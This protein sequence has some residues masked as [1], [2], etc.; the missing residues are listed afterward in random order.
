MDKVNIF[1]AILYL[2]PGFLHIEIYRKFYP[3]KKDT[4]FARTLHSVFWSLLL[5]AIA[6]IIDY[7][8]STKI[9]TCSEVGLYAGKV[10]NIFNNSAVDISKVFWLYFL[11][12]LSAYIRVFSRN[13]RFRAKNTKFNYFAPKEQNLWH[14]INRQKNQWAVIITKDGSRY[15]GY[16]SDYTYDIESP[17]DI[18]LLLAEASC[19][20][21]FL[22]EKYKI[23]GRG[24]YMKIN[25][26]SKIEFYK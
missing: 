13:L 20:D 3:T 25:E 19:V 15:L 6:S 16:L 18:D 12:F 21:E 23:N 11:A 1:Q 7:S 4:D 17:N 26:I 9:I 24:L 14:E 2:L 22:N 10:K 5:F 8:F